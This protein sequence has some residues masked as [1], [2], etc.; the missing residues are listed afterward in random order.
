MLTFVGTTP[1]N[2]QSPLYQAHIE[3]VRPG[4]TAARHDCSAWRWVRTSLR[5]PAVQ[6]VTST[7]SA[8]AP[9]CASLVSVQLAALPATVA[10]P[11]WK[12]SGSAAGD[13][14]ARN[15]SS[16]GFCTRFP[17]VGSGGAGAGTT[18]PVASPLI[19]SVEQR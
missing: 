17:V 8:T 14:T 5:S 3:Y 18:P 13:F 19:A 15:S 6:F 7:R 1:E 12:H 16:E 2:A 10:P 4:S 9:E 11:C